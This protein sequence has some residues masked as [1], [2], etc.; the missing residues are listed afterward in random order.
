MSALLLALFS[1]LLLYLL[2]DLHGG[3]AVGK[4][5][6]HSGVFCF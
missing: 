4:G 2:A 1:I 5:N 3:T 6:K